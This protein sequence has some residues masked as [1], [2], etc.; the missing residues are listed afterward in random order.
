MSIEFTAS[1]TQPQ[2]FLDKA[3]SETPVFTDGETVDAEIR[4]EIDTHLYQIR[5]R[6]LL[7]NARTNLKL[8]PGQTLRLKAGIQETTGKIALSILGDDSPARGGV[9]ANPLAV[10]LAGENIPMTDRNQRIAME[11]LARGITVSRELVMQIDT[12][13]TSDEEVRAAVDVVKSG[14]PLT[15]KT[16]AASTQLISGQPPSDDIKELTRLLPALRK[17]FDQSQTPLNAWNTPDAS[18]SRNEL[19]AGIRDWIESNLASRNPAELDLNSILET[20]NRNLG[21]TAAVLKK[22]DI[23]LSALAHF[24]KTGH[25]PSPAELRNQLTQTPP[26]PSDLSESPQTSVAQVPENA[27][28]IAAVISEINTLLSTT[29]QAALNT[30]EKSILQQF[31]AAFPELSRDRGFMFLL[32]LLHRHI[33]DQAPQS[34]DP[35]PHS[36]VQ[37]L[38]Q[39]ILSGNA[40]ERETSQ[41]PQQIRENTGTRMVHIERILQTIESET[42][43]SV[44]NLRQTLT[45]SER[46]QN[47]LAMFKS[48]NMDVRPGSE[49]LFATVP[50]K[51][52]QETRDVNVHIFKKK[53][54]NERAQ[55]YR[56]LMD[57]HLSKLG[58]V[59]ADFHTQPSSSSLTFYFES[60][61]L[62]AFAERSRVDIEKSLQD[63]DVLA[64]VWFRK[65]EQDIR[66][67]VEEETSLSRGIDIRG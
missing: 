60:D 17:I 16:I 19:I 54:K 33:S 13:T 6:N 48:L 8:T 66:E 5:I 63:S 36:S 67:M 29:G 40:T 9:S 55:D 43:A 52:N 7:L 39:Q 59:I 64:T 57:L 4:K 46:V 14:L 1:G 37:S 45:I 21:D 35:P 2:L 3:G 24:R 20:E 25:F 34:L 53:R 26:T 27:N 47:K 23:L 41:L 61:E 28:A 18:R 22:T 42:L 62:A 11:M 44:K 49:F 15:T 10:V 32:S 12:M 50:V 56:I 51:F 65:K 30:A 38:L 31:S 58:N